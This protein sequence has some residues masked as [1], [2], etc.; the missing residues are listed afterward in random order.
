MI[1]RNRSSWL[2]STATLIG[3]ALV[4]SCSGAPTPST[5]AGAEP[6]PPLVEPGAANSESVEQPATQKP[7]ET[8]LLRRFKLTNEIDVVVL[9][10]E[11]GI[12][13]CAEIG[14]LLAGGT[15][16]GQPGAADLA[17]HLLV[18]GADVT[19][20]RL[21]LQR[22]IEN[23]GGTFTVE[24]GRLS[25]W[26]YARV[27]QGIWQQAHAA[28]ASALQAPTPGRGMLERSQQDLLTLR[29]QSI[30]ADPVGLTTMRLLLGDESPSA[31]VQALQDR[32]PIEAVLFQKR[33]FRPE[34]TV[35]A[36]R[37]PGTAEQ[38]EAMAKKD[39]GGWIATKVEPE[40]EAAAQQ[41]V[42]PSGIV[43]IERETDDKDAPCDVEVVL[44]WPSQ[45]ATDALVLHLLANCITEDGLG[46]R[47]ER[48]LQEAGLARLSLV[49][50][51]ATFGETSALVLRTELPAARALQ[52]WTILGKARQSL[53]DLPPTSS[54]RSQARGAAWLSLR[55]SEDRPATGLR[56][57]VERIVL[58]IDENTLLARVQ[59]LASPEAVTV[60]AI[61]RFLRLPLAII[62]RGPRPS[63]GAQDVRMCEL[64]PSQ[65]RTPP[66]ATPD[67]ARLDAAK[68]WL[69]RTVDAIG[70]SDLLGRVQGLAATRKIATEGAP[71]VEETFTW[72]LGGGMHRS[73]TV[74][75]VLVETDLK[76]SEWTETSGGTKVQLSP[77]E[78]N[79][80]LG[81][82][83]RHPLVLLAGWQRDAM[84]FRLLTTRVVG[85]REHVLLEAISGRFERLRMEIDQ[86]SG[87]VRVVEAWTLSPEGTPTRA[88]DTWSDYRTV[89]G[90]RVPFRCSTQIDDGQS[91]RVSTFSR[92]QPQT[93]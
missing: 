6:V 46:G 21:S 66:T 83:E 30:T 9:R 65:R 17:T 43:W 92:V 26:L 55:S 75:G 74:L 16:R 79:W 76:A 14:V 58:D 44:Q 32:D 50:S 85:D 23:L 61:E 59:A 63:D 20:G 45:H 12:A 91:S 88:V 52:L 67:D 51:V 10:H 27:P 90:L 80:R 77:V 11:P 89:V 4:A 31:H 69:A 35:V 93:K 2:A 71:D 86:Q 84:K 47:L 40:P 68:P 18:H 15:E 38:V 7:T 3:A 62:V 60:T 57:L 70:G 53:L 73:R 78:A 39:L 13:K 82:I 54:E 19:T 24:Q 29:T 56:A 33:Y 41:R 42:A 25:T 5:A 48:L 36:L 81:E 1:A 64:L 72:S 49:P 37:V 28:I 22:R 8:L 87:L 34:S